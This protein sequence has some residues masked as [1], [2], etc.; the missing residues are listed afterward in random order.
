[1]VADGGTRAVHAWRVARRYGIPARHGD[2]GRHPRL[3][4][5]QVVIEAMALV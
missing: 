5:G 3:R 1:V 2:R 4:D